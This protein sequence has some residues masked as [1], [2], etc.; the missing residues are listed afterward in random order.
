MPFFEFAVTRILLQDN[1]VVGT[2]HGSWMARRDDSNPYLQVDFPTYME[3][4]GII[5]Q[6]GY[7]I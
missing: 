3:I 4:K 5:T 7:S 6:V 2:G 1:I